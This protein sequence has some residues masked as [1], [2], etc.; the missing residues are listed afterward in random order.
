MRKNRAVIL[1]KIESTYGTDPTPAPDT[2][3]I[4]CEQPE[5]EVV[6]KKLERKNVTTYYGA[7]PV[8]NVGQ[9]LKI[10]FATELKGSGAAGT[11]PEIG[12]LL[13]ACNF[14]ETVTPAT[15]AD[16]APNSLNLTAESATIW[17]YQ[18][19]ILHK[20]SGC[21]GTVSF[22]A[23]ATEYV[24]LKWE[25]QGLYAG[26]SDAT[27]PASPTFNATVPPV[28]KAASFALDSYA[29]VIENL[30]VT[31]KNDIAMR[32]DANA[33]T[34]ISQYFVKDRQITG[35]VDPEVVALATK[36]FWTMWSA[37]SRV[38]MTA[39]IA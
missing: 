11:A 33:A 3:A 2:N 16:Y 23:K 22:D 30:K 15:K 8:V 29:A 32:P 24:S 36:D 39:T 1:A 6:G 5:F 25:F 10:S 28:F 14:T 27:I 31:V 34:G 21:R 38:A 17:F 18:D 12:V 9:G 13:R 19:G 37:S 7:L 26:P 4:L 20:L 35:E